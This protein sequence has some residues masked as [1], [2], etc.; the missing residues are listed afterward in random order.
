[1]SEGDLERFWKGLMRAVEDAY[2]MEGVDP[3]TV[4]QEDKEALAQET[5]ERLHEDATVRAQEILDAEFLR[6]MHEEFDRL[7]ELH[8]EIRAV[9]QKALYQAVVERV[10]K[11]RGYIMKPRLPEPPRS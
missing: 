9:S 10:N 11:E 7:L 5:L 3:D 4:P 1:M 2:R 6:I 8:P